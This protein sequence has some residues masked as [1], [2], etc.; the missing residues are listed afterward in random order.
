MVTCESC[1]LQMHIHITS[2]MRVD[3]TQL[4]AWAYRS[5]VLA[6]RRRCCALGTGF[7][8]TRE[9]M[10]QLS[11]QYYSLA[12]LG[13]RLEKHAQAM[14]STKSCAPQ[15]PKLQTIGSHRCCFAWSANP[16]ANA[17]SHSLRFSWKNG[18][19][20]VLDTSVWNPTEPVPETSRM[21]DVACGNLAEPQ[22]CAD[23]PQGLN[24]FQLNLSNF[25]YWKTPLP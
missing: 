14:I 24:M 23:F 2:E 7:Q 6:Q 9:S 10:R 15:C 16:L 5:L 12:F 25:T 4:P 1:T 13:P 20:P 17:R 19:L 11:I 18:H 22:T 3:L 21:A 8:W